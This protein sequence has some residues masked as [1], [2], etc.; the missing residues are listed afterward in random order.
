M[1]GWFKAKFG[2]KKEAEAPAEA[3]AEVVPGVVAEAEALLP[4]SVAV[5]ESQARDAVEPIGE[6]PPAIEVA[7]PGEEKPSMVGEAAER[8]PAPAEA[9]GG[10][11]EKTLFARLQERLG[12][13]RKSLLYRLDTLFLGKK[14]I[15]QEL[16]DDL[17][18]ILIT[19][20]LGVTTVH[21]LLDEV[22]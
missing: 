16:Y 10:K 19:A 3:G 15:D 12:K 4:E 5:P 8:R 21:A 17:E 14:V 2:K 20:D 22:R 6:T 9:A 18:E 13:T 7:R 1:L 11:E